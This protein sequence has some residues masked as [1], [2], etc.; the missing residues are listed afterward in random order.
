MQRRRKKGLKMGSL[1]IFGISTFS[2]LEHKK[3]DKPEGKRR[4][5]R[6]SSKTHKSLLLVEKTVLPILCLHFPPSG[7][8]Q[9]Q[10]LIFFSILPFLLLPVALWT[11]CLWPSSA[12][13]PRSQRPPRGGATRRTDALSSPSP[14]STCSTR[15][16]RWGTRWSRQERLSRGTTS[17]IRGSLSGRCIRHTMSGSRVQNKSMDDGSM[18]EEWY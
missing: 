14:H 11:A 3:W 2:L 9:F 1:E 7:M 6:E 16:S 8:W 18:Q 15:S 10:I 12:C 17:L 4:R 5:H 13:W